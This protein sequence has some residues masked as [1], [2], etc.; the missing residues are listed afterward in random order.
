MKKRTLLVLVCLAMVCMVAVNGTLAQEIEKTFQNVVGFVSG[1]FGA[2]EAD[3]ELLEV[4]LSYQKRSGSALVEMNESPVLYPSTYPADFSWD[5]LVDVTIGGYTYRL[6]DDRKLRGAMDKFTS[7]TNVRTEDAYLRVAFAVKKNAAADRVVHVNFNEDLS[8]F[9]ITDWRDVTIDGQAY[10]MKI[11]TYRKALKAG[12]STPPM[13]LQV[14]IDSS[15]TN[16]DFTAIG[17]DFLRVNAM[18]I[19]AGAFTT[20]VNGEKVQMSYQEALDMALPLD[21]ITPFHE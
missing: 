11:F 10:R 2:P 15:A 13:L 18:A 4:K 8:A 17:N 5:Q 19:Q 3:T 20:E 7:V 1:L 14:A 12:E 21:T 16:E 6:W 9:D